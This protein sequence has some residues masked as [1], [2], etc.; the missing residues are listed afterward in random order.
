M[1][2][3]TFDPDLPECGVIHRDLRES[4]RNGGITHRGVEVVDKATVESGQLSFVV[5]TA[6][7][8]YVDLIAKTS[9]SSP[10]C[11]GK[12]LAQVGRALMRLSSHRLFAE[13]DGNSC[14]V[15]DEEDR[16]F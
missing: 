5:E 14:F 3:P 13:C 4:S 8:S 6:I 16:P 11:D 10:I 2:G 7:R 12:A 1:S 15:C 9:S